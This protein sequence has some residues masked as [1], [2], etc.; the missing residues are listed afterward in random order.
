M[1]YPGFVQARRVFT[2]AIRRGVLVT[3]ALFACAALAEAQ[4]LTPIHVFDV[5]DG[6]YPWSSLIQ[7]NDGYFYGTTS[8]GGSDNGSAHGSVY[9]MTYD[10]TVTTLHAFTGRP[11]GAAPAAALIQARDGN[12]YGTTTGGGDND[13]GTVFRMTPAG[14]VTILHSFAGPD[15]RTPQAGLLEARDGNLYGG[16]THGGESGLGRLFRITTAGSFT[17][18]HSFT[19]AEG[20]GLWNSLIQAFDGNLYGASNVIFRLTVDG[21][22]S[23]TNATAGAGAIVQS[24][25]GNFYGYGWT[26]GN[27]GTVFQLTPGGTLTTLHV[28]IGGADGDVPIGNLIQTSDGNF[29]GATLHGGSANAGTIFKMTPTGS[30]TILHAFSGLDGRSPEAGLLHA[31]DGNLYGTTLMGGSGSP[32]AGVVF[33]VLNTAPCDDALAVAYAAGTLTMGFTLKSAA[34]ATWSTWLIAPAASTNLW[35][36]PIPV[37]SPAVSFSVPVPGIPSVGNIVV[38]SILSLTTGPVCADVKIVK[39]EP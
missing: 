20:A 19:P 26:T 28:F 8:A 13:W 35:S 22:F 16:T 7:A 6:A 27:L 9:R 2:A 36:I 14:A 38:L 31:R 10:G 29:Y 11:D 24:L 15:G 37:I 18:L 39:T 23:V 25:D 12:F 1:K 3:V 5:A 4:G 34:P 30:V 32:A 21:T 33:R 17:P